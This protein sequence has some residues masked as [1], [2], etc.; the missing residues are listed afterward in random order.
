MPGAVLFATSIGYGALARDAGFD[1]G[2]ALTV[3][4][5]L[6]ALPAQ[7]V[8]VDQ[9]SRG[10]GL[11]GAAFLVTLT[12]IR[13]LPM[14]VTMMPFLRAGPERRWH[15][16]AA[17][18]FVAITTWLAANERLPTLPAEERLPY[19]VGIGLSILAFAMTGTTFG[20]FAAS[21]V[22]GIVAAALLF[23][24]PIYFLVSLLKAARVADDHLALLLGCLLGPPL[25]LAVPGFDLLLTGVLGGTI[26]YIIGRR[27]RS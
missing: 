3:A 14:T 6:Y 17:V 15:H 26:A 7:V 8:F 12:A 10:A 2:Q 23:M 5:A 20:F 18:H 1:L 22:P 27:R 25:Y 16:F 21:A 4:A 9:I 11:A 19:F 24:T 13:F